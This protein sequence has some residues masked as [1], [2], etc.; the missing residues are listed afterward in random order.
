MTITPEMIQAVRW[1]TG[2]VDPTL[3]IMSSDEITY[4][5]TKHTESIRRA[6]LD[7]AKTILFKI[8]MTAGRK[9][10]DILSIDTSKS[11]TAYKEALLAYI[12]NDA[13]NGALGNILPY[14]GGISNSDM[15]ANNTSDVNY[16]KPPV[17]YT[18]I[19]T[20]TF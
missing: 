10:I 16:V 17:V 15:Q 11:A 3:P 18:D 19:T 13:L 20:L 5:L 1:E 6:S 2:D 4:Y 9:T 14:A 8:S 12:K 7:V